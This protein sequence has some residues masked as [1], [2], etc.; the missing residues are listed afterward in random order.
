[1]I[2]ISSLAFRVMCFQSDRDYYRYLLCARSLKKFALGLHACMVPT[3]LPM[4]VSPSTAI[5]GLLIIPLTLTSPHEACGQH[6]FITSL[7]V[8][9]PTG[10][11]FSVTTKA[12]MFFFQPSALL[13]LGQKLHHQL[14]SEAWTSRFL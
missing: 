14:L 8:T 12:P 2:Q 6:F 4:G 9:I 5:T 3:A 10:L 11:A 7:S 1:M 13:R